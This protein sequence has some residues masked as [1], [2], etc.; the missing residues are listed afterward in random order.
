MHLDHHSLL[1]VTR[2]TPDGS[3]LHVKESPTL[4]RP[5]GGRRFR[6]EREEHEGNK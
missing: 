1:K 4:L 2:P 5:A 6:E 3:D